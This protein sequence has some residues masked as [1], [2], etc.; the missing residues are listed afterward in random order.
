MCYHQIQI[1]SLKFCLDS[2]DMSSIGSTSKQSITSNSFSNN[3]DICTM[4]SP[5]PQAN[6]DFESVASSS[7]DNNRVKDHIFDG[8][9]DFFEKVSS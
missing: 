7:Q 8:L 1:I 2:L 9:I 3:E 4:D 5:V 6:N